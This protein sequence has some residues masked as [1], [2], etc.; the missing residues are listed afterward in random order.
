MGWMG[1]VNGGVDGVDGVDGWM[2]GL[3]DGEVCPVHP[4]MQC[5]CVFGLSCSGQ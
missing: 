4:C 3:M 2:G 1:E 5:I